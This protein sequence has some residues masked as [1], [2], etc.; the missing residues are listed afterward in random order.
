MQGMRGRRRD[1]SS[2]FRDDCRAT[3]RQQFAFVD[4]PPRRRIDA[5]FHSIFVE[6]ST[7]VA[8]EILILFSFF[9]FRCGCR[10]EDHLYTVLMLRKVLYVVYV[11]VAR[12][13]AI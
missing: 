11:Y 5:E 2:I 13:M 10:F 4:S 9:G 8:D 7:V 1:F 3:E 6:F 12:V